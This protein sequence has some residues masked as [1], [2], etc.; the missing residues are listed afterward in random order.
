VACLNAWWPEGAGETWLRAGLLILWGVVVVLDRPRWGRLW[1]MILAQ[2]LLLASLLLVALLVTPDTWHHV[3]RRVV[4]R[5]AVGVAWVLWLA[6]TVR[7]EELV[8]VLRAW[9]FPRLLAELLEWIV[10]YGRIVQAELERMI[11]AAR[12]RG[13]LRSAWAPAS[14]RGCGALGGVLICRAV[15]RAERVQEALACRGGVEP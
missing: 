4:P 9:G 12:L 13:G 14:W 7:M 11:V 5:V 3:T 2:A 10:R 6:A 15:Q 1:P 8:G